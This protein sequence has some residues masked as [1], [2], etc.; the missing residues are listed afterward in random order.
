[1]VDEEFERTLSDEKS[2]LPQWSGSGKTPI[3]LMDQVVSEYRDSI[4]DLF[5]NLLPVYRYTF[6][7]EFPFG[8]GAPADY[9]KC[10]AII[11]ECIRK[12]KQYDEYE[13]A[14]APSGA[15]F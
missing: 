15:R 5:K 12:G 10:C 8:F 2:K 1:M 13:E 4:E 7:E 6:G 3:K 11:E 14:G 9:E